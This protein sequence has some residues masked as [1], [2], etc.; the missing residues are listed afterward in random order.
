MGQRQ[1]QGTLKIYYLLTI[2]LVID[3]SLSYIILWDVVL[4]S[5]NCYEN[6]HTQILQDM[7]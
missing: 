6:L 3:N 2:Q 4:T 1:E 7:I 5:K